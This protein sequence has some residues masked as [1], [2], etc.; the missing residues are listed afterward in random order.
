MISTNSDNNLLQLYKRGE[1]HKLATKDLTQPIDSEG[2]TVI[3]RMAENLDKNALETIRKNNPAALKYEVVNKPN[4]RYELPIHKAMETIQKN[5]TGGQADQNFINYLVEQLGAVQN[6]PDNKNRIIINQAAEKS[7]DDEQLKRLNE[8]V[9]ENIRN[10]NKLS[11]NQTAGFNNTDTQVDIEFIKKITNYYSQFRNTENQTGGYNGQRKIRNYFSNGSSERR[12]NSFV[13]SNKN[14]LLKEYDRNREES[15]RKSNRHTVKNNRNSE[16]KLF[17]GK[18]KKIKSFMDNWETDDFKLFTETDT[19]RNTKKNNPTDVSDEEIIFEDEM[20]NIRN[21]YNKTL[22]DDFENL[23]IDSVNGNNKEET[24]IRISDL[25]EDDVNRQSFDDLYF[26]TQERVRDEKADEIYRSFVKKIMDL[27]GVDEET[28]RFYRW[29]LKI[30]LIKANPELKRDEALKLSEME[31]FFENK[32]KLQAI[33]DKI[34]MDAIKKY[35][36]E[37][38][39]A[40]ERRRK[41]RRRLRKER[42]RLRRERRQRQTEETTEKPS[43]ETSDAAV[44]EN[45]VTDTTEEAPKTKK[46]ATRKSKVAENGYLLSDEII[47]S[48]N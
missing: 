36:D 20:S 42:R 35:R 11:Q 1:Y 25:E 38:R 3:H 5:Q 39:E 22:D 37:L 33:L 2:N 19:R 9:K 13:V 30:N 10:L 34:D 41:E 31:K 26:S 16:S 27:L 48:P 32:E 7:V 6:I 46:R 15:T 4:K 12:N 44:T 29:A 18:Y 14:E 17:G 24:E 21:E 47:F 23:T 45:T 43:E 8:T 40:A 28:A